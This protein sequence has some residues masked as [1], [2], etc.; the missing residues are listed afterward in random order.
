MNTESQK[1]MDSA[2][3]ITRSEVA[4][5]L[6]LGAQ[7]PNPDGSLLKSLVAKLFDEDVLRPKNSILSNQVTLK[8]RGDPFKTPPTT[9][10]AKTIA[11]KSTI[12]P[13]AT[14]DDLDSLMSSVTT[15]SLKRNV[16]SSSSTMDD[17]EEDR[18]VIDPKKYTNPLENLTFTVPTTSGLPP[19][20]MKRPMK[21]EPAADPED[22]AVD[23][24]ILED[25]EDDDDVD[26]FLNEQPST[27]KTTWNDEIDPLDDLLDS[28]S[29]E[30]T[31]KGP[32]DE[33]ENEDLK[34][35]EE[36]NKTMERLRLQTSEFGKLKKESPTESA[37]TSQ[38]ATEYEDDFGSDEMEELEVDD[39]A[40]ELGPDKNAERGDNGDEINSIDL[41]I[42]IEEDIDE[43]IEFDAESDLVSNGTE[44][45]ED[46]I[47][48][49]K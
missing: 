28:S 21:S 4:S 19:L 27:K 9:N 31:D 47:Y 29:N 17:V 12:S 39:K 7:K 49:A 36:M 8:P 45:A 2:N 44:D 11:G 6:G 20:S 13:S 37:N 5:R 23:L 35:M 32:E 42:D 41:D 1:K 46:N 30:G 16:K 15:S 48:S 18:T 34:R 33:V 43:D 14:M 10:I 26:Q 22:D 25:D 38:A 24:S 40:Q 3:H